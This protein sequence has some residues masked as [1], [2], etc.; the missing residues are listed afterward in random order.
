[1]NDIQPIPPL[2]FSPLIIIFDKIASGVSYVYTMYLADTIDPILPIIKGVLSILSA[3]FAAIII[4][5]LLKIQYLVKEDS[6]KYAP[7]DVE[8][9]E[10]QKQQIAWEVI[11]NH[12]NSP[13]QAEWKLAIIEADSI[14]DDLLKEI[15][16]EG[17]TVA[18]KLRAAGDGEAIGWAWEAHKMRNKIAHEGGT[19]ITQREAK[20]IIELYERVF[21]K[22]GY[23]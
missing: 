19:D 9:S 5:L 15:G 16:Y 20:R 3:L 17:E 22:F 7:V 6:K 12:V 2:D 13:N 10:K 14:L 21:K 4:F 8:G 1:M 11:R 18:E 23:L